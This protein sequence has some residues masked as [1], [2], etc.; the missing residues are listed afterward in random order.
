MFGREGDGGAGRGA[1]DGWLVVLYL[2]GYCS[3]FFRKLSMKKTSFFG[4]KG[5]R[6]EIATHSK[7]N[8][9]KKREAHSS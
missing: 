9:E 1:M 5:R 2:V 3:S 4:G 7:T 6:Y 8:I